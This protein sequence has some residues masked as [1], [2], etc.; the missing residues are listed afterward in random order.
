MKLMLTS[1]AKPEKR[2]GS[3]Y[4]FL[5]NSFGK[6]FEFPLKE[7]QIKDLS[8]KLEFCDLR[9]KPNYIFSTAI[10]VL[11][12]GI[13]LSLFFFIFSLYIYGILL[14]IAFSMFSWYLLIYPSYLTRSYRIKATSDLVQTILYLVISLRLVP[15]LESALMF[16]STNVKGIVG[17]DLRKMTWD[18]STGKYGSADEV[19]EKFAKKWKRENLEFFEAVHLIRT[20]TLQRKGKR[21]QMLDEAVNVM[22][23]GNMERMKHYSTQLRNPLMIITSLGITLPVLTIIMFPIMTIFLAETIKPHLLFLFYDVCLPIV[24]YYIM[25]Q[26]LRARPLSFGVIDI[27]KHPEVKS[28]IIS[29]NL[30]GKRLEFPNMVLSVI[31]GSIL[32]LTGILITL[33]P[34]DPVSITKIGGGLII[35]TGISSSVIVFSFLHF[36]GNIEIRNEVKEIEKEF[37]EIL[38]QLGYTL[39]TGVPLEKALEESCKRTK[40]LKISGMFER[41][42]SNIKRFGF[43]FKR[44]LFDKKYGV[45]R[46]YP[47]PT[48]HSM[49]S[50]ISDSIEK[51]VAGVAKTVLSISHYL[52]SM[53]LVE[54]HMKEILDETTS[55]M[56][57]MMTLLVPIASGAVVGMA[58]IIVMV[59]FQIVNILTN[60]TGLATAY[61]QSFAPE[62]LGSL[63]DIKNILPAEIFLVVVGV[64]MLEIVIM[65]ASFVG[66][67]E[68]GDDPL[69]KHYLIATN[70]LLS[71]CIFTACILIIYFIFRNII[72][73]WGVPG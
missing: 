51:G 37:S 68:Y 35:L 22:L 56:R 14:I 60:V 18:I 50:T 29:I 3:W 55:S 23:E 26:T 53:H 8:E 49:M 66:T 13:F 63:V 54:E 9:I 5:C 6:T 69:D 42:L 15:N 73:F 4:E 27:S 52:K 62:M 36:H 7:D 32:C 71:L 25:R 17:R 67:L 41:A 43:T 61:P 72:T 33:I 64:Y 31:I 39:S 70:I 21:E 47:S 28:N 48:V 20:S 59:L 45:M 2:K 24:I 1:K 10:I 44:S 19:L 12:I 58:T 16:A 34:G 46:Y 38:F 30:L 57:M 11:I 40:G 65:L